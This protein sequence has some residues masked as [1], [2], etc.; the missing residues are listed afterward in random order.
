MIL[1]VNMEAAKKSVYTHMLG[2]AKTGWP[3]DGVR[4][5]ASKASSPG[6]CRLST[7]PTS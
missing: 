3:A 5:E 6:I 7:L 2:S 4:R 1:H